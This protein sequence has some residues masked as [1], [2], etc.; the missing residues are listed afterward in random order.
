MAE[1]GTPAAYAG[2]DGSLGYASRLSF[3]ADLGGQLGDP[4]L[5]ESAASLEAKVEALAV[6]V[7]RAKHVVAFTGA[8]I[9]TA[10]GIPDF[11]GP[12]GVWTLQRKGRPPPK[13]ST[14]F[15]LAAPSLTHQALLGLRSAGKL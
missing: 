12:E 15:A 6:L 5:A 1:E 8:G 4:E 3:R 7:R 13:A 14:P 10:T 11:R 2:S 9:S